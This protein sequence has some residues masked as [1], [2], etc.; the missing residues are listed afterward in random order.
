MQG[1]EGWTPGFAL[2]IAFMSLNVLAMAYLGLRLL[3]RFLRSGAPTGFVGIA[4][5]FGGAPCHA[6]LTAALL[7][8]S[9]DSS[10]PWQVVYAG[11]YVTAGIAAVS[12]L[13]FAHEVFWPQSRA[14]S[15]LGTAVAAYFAGVACTLP[16]SETTPRE[17]PAALGVFATLFAIFAWSSFESF[18]TWAR[19]RHVP[20]LDPVVVESF[21]LWGVAALAVLA[22]VGVMRLTTESPLG[23][24]AAGLAGLGCCAMLWLA[25]LPPA[26]WRRRL[27][28]PAPGAP[29]TRGGPPERVAGP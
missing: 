29:R 23:V 28:S 20:G 17:H 2:A 12:V 1:W 27:G 21:R 22:L 24:A 10:G 16:F 15:W 8:G 5:L 4:L 6:L 18:R 26:A 9:P 7:A 3:A 13:R 25:F 14:L 19:Y 11:F